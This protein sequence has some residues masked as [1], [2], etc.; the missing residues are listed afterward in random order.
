MAMTQRWLPSALCLLL[1][2]A[3]FGPAAAADMHGASP[4]RFAAPAEEAVEEEKAAPTGIDAALEEYDPLFDE[5]PEFGDDSPVYDPFET[6]N[7][8][9]YQFNQQVS[10]YVWNPLATGYRFVVPN[11]ARMAVRRSRPSAPSP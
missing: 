9:I 2:L 5:D 3:A 8:A 10:T 1:A 4:S 6:G 11:P 7:R